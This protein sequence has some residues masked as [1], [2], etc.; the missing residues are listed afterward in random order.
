M[1]K[2]LIILICLPF[3]VFSQKIDKFNLD[4][5]RELGHCYDKLTPISDDADGHSPLCSDSSVRVF[6][7]EPDY[8][9]VYN[10]ARG[11]CGSCG[12]SMNIYKRDNHKYINK[13]QICCIGVDINQPL[14]DYII[15]KD[16]IKKLHCCPGFS[17]KLRLINDTIRL[18][19]IISYNH[20]IIRDEDHPLDCEYNDSLWIQKEWKKAEEPYFFPNQN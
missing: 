19:E 2:T 8:Y 16:Q 5:A 20:N 1:K 10:E 4:I 17:G 12:C 18:Y 13:G 9:C 3:I 15:I 6:F 11:W 7:L 14:A